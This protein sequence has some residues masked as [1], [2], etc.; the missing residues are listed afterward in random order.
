MSLINE[1]AE[2][3]LSEFYLFRSGNAIVIPRSFRRS[4]SEYS[5]VLPLPQDTRSKDAQSVVATTVLSFIYMT[6]QLILSVILSENIKLILSCANLTKQCT[7]ISLCNFNYHKI[8]FPRLNVINSVWCG[9]V[10]S[11]LCKSGRYVRK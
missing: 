9:S 11:H 3:S 8:R 7:K 4:S 6:S 1:S 10:K 5:S 2:E